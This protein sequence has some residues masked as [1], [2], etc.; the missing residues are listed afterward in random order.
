MPFLT[1][2]AGRLARRPAQNAKFNSKVWSIPE[3]R[4]MLEATGW[5]VRDRLVVRRDGVAR[6]VGVVVLLRVRKGE[7]L[8]A[9]SRGR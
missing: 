7:A 3:A 4:M 8:P 5:L 6:G 2:R 1:P 9:S